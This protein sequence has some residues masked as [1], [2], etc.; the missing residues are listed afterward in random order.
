MTGLA[1]RFVAELFGGELARTGQR[2]WDVQ[3]PEG[4]IQVKALWD[5]GRRTRRRLGTIGTEL[6]LLVAVIFDA[7]GRIAEVWEVGADSL[8]LLRGE[9]HRVVIRLPWVRQVGKA[10]TEA[11]IRAA[12]RALQLD[13][14]LSA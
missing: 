12:A 6:D 3:A 14:S 13:V 4:L 10:V 11:R 9:A 1:E 7:H 2:D 5:V 8:E